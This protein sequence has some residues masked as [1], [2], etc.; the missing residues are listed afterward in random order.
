MSLLLSAAEEQ[1]PQKL[2]QILE[3][4]KRSQSKTREKLLS[5]IY[6]KNLQQLLHQKD[7][8]AKLAKKILMWLCHAQ[9]PLTA[10]ALCHALSGQIEGT[11][12]DESKIPA[13]DRI[14]NVCVGLVRIH[15]ETRFVDFANPSTKDFIRD[16]RDKISFPTAGLD[17]SRTCLSYLSLQDFS[18]LDSMYLPPVTFDAQ[19]CHKQWEER[20]PFYSY[21]ARYWGFHAQGLPEHDLCGLIS[22]FL[23]QDADNWFCRATTSLL[24]QVGRSWSYGQHYK[25]PSRLSGIHLAVYFG[26]KTSLEFLLTR[27][28]TELKDSNGWTPLWWA[29]I[30]TQDF[31]IVRFLLGRSADPDS[32]DNMGQTIILMSLQPTAESEFYT[33]Y[34]DFNIS[35]QSMVHLGEYTLRRQA[36]AES[37]FY[38]HYDFSISDFRIS[39]Q[40]KV[41]LGE[42]YT[43]SSQAVTF[44]S[45]DDRRYSAKG[46]GNHAIMKLLT[47]RTKI[48]N[49]SDNKGQTALSIAARYWQ[50][51]FVA[52]LLRKG[53]NKDRTNHSGMTA[54]LEALGRL[55]IQR[56][57]I[58]A[59]VLVSGQS[60]V[61]MGD[62]FE[63][64]PELVFDPSEGEEWK[65]SSLADERPVSG[66]R[67]SYR[68]EIFYDFETNWSRGHGYVALKMSKPIPQKLKSSNTSRNAHKTIREAIMS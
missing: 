32:R 14:I 62:L 49:A 22:D 15:K 58:F 11:P 36:T 55:S 20:L 38:T 42:R 52:Q 56:K 8:D 5:D 4:L 12:F 6:E 67:L 19:E 7:S 65:T 68:L 21:A 66:V 18:D 64:G 24:S 28:N 50:W 27:R 25:L 3:D 33:H 29:A 54:L 41:Y 23:D 63:L 16:V 39:G 51:D 57:S 26:L 45:Y 40:S 2:K 43:W 48:I 59:D 34:N 47:S 30:I 9:V 60:I 46:L 37:E 31:E 61:H 1:I 53:A 35:G 10:S 13:Q 17:I 44:D